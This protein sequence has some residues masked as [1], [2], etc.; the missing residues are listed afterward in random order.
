M[1]TYT[2]RGRQPCGDRLTLDQMNPGDVGC[3]EAVDPASPLRERLGD[4]GVISGAHL[5]CERV[6]LFGDPIAYRIL[7]A[8]KGTPLGDA[9]AGTVIALRRQDAAMVAVSV[10]GR[11]ETS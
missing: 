2:D 3:V 1:Q 7:P 11:R 9:G 8:W 6:S 10:T 4:V 5:A